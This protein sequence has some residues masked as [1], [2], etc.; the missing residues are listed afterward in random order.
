MRQIERASIMRIV[1]DLIKAD[2][3]IDE[4]EIEFLST[5]RDK[6][7]I[8]RDD[9]VVSASMTLAKAIDTLSV[10]PE[11][12]RNDLVDDFTK[13]AMSDDYCAREEAVI[14][15]SLLGCLTDKF[16]C[17]GKVLSVDSSVMNIEDS[18]MLYIESEYDND[19]NENILAFYREI[20]A[21]AR[22][23]GFD[24]VYL[25]QIAEH[26]K[27]IPKEKLLQ[28][29]S[30]LYPA[31]NAER[32]SMVTDQ[33][34]N[35]STAEFCRDLLSAKLNLKE[36]SDILPSVMFKIGE[37]IIGGKSYINFL[38]IEVEHNILDMIRDILDTFSE[39]YHTIRLNYQREERGRF[40]YSG[41]YKQLFDLQMLRKG[42]KSTV[43]IDVYR[44]E[45]RFPE[46]DAKVEKLHRRE[47][48]LYALFLLESASGGINF[49]KP[50]TPKGLERYN[51]RIQTVQ[52]KYA[53]IYRKF[54]GESDNAPDLGVSEIRLPMI[55]LIKR[56]IRKLGEV[57]H[58][59]DD[60]T[61]QRNI[62]GNY[63]LGI[64]SSLCCCCGADP[65]DI[66]LL[67]ESDEWIKISAL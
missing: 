28:I 15:L 31:A 41:F 27:S 54:G 49:K 47:K 61:I 16:G 26:Y 44:D 53:L 14:I 64:P 38:V 51:R 1:S 3:I 20:S 19:V 10:S 50:D 35:I 48:A 57:L 17:Q 33:I 18:Q 58:N 66:K 60:Y 6:Y 39:Y 2:A 5:I 22:L 34:C 45:I 65:T 13:V 56:Q 52:R 29:T 11:N 32:C 42:I 63:G 23:A 37:T 9:V 7:A 36:F 25:P 40:V 59:I 30:F 8:K 12:L 46:A 67:T 4:R 55:A 43:V 24:F 21:E 62:Y